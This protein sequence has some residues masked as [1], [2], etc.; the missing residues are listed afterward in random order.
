VIVGAFEVG[1]QK[2]RINRYSKMIM[3]VILNIAA[4]EYN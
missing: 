3:G 2:G 4:P 1:A